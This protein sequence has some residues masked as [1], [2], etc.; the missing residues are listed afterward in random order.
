MIGAIHNDKELMGKKNIITTI[1]ACIC[2]SL[3][4][5]AVGFALP[6]SAT[7]SGEEQPKQDTNNSKYAGLYITQGN[8]Y[9][10]D[11]YSKWYLYKDGTCAR[12]EEKYL[13]NHFEGCTW[14]VKSNKLTATVTR[15][16][17]TCESQDDCE[18]SKKHF[19]ASDEMIITEL[20][21]GDRDYSEEHKYAMYTR[22]D[23]NFDILDDGS[24]SNENNIYVR[25]S[26]F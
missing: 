18:K 16:I 15:T 12:T 23:T 17:T 4:A 26:T 6:H 25:R 24:L 22:E 3:V 8:G 9:D 21:E 7:E 13:T 19:I 2:C 20:Q 11:G 1:V 5:F 10:T 14:S